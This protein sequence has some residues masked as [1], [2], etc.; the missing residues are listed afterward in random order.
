MILLCS[1]FKLDL[2]LP[3]QPPNRD[4]DYVLTYG[5]RVVNISTIWL[6]YPVTS[7]HLGI[8]FDLDIE[9][10]FKSSYLDIAPNP[11]RS[12]T[13]VNGKSN[14]TKQIHL[15]KLVDRIDILLQK[16]TNASLSFMESDARDLNDIDTQLTETMLSSERLCARH[17]SH[18]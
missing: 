2:I 7:D 12:L 14:V 4:I 5:I 8:I 18:W 9:S 13:S 3:L 17:K 6:N 15:H 10:Y 11:P 1:Y 16:A